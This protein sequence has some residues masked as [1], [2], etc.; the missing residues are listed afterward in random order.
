M[1]ITSNLPGKTRVAPQKIAEDP[2][3][4]NAWYQG[5]EMGMAFCRLTERLSAESGTKVEKELRCL[6]RALQRD[7]SKLCGQKDVNLIDLGTG[8]GQ[9][10]ILVI[11]ALNES[12]I[13]AVRYVPVD[14][15]PYIARYAILSI[16]GSGKKAWNKQEA[17]LLFGPFEEIGFMEAES[18]GSISLETL[19]RLSRS[20][21]MRSEGFV[22]KGVTVPMTGLDIDFF[23]HL[24]KVTS[25]AKALPGK[26]IN[27][28]CMLGNT[29]GNN[30]PQE[31]K[32]FLDTLC[33][34]MEEGDL[35]LLGVSLRPE[36]EPC[37][38][39]IRILEREYSVGEAFMR[40]GAD[41]PQSK[42]S[43]KYDPD[44]HCMIYGFERPDKSV[45][46]MGYSY[47]F[48][49]REAANNLEAAGFEVVA[50]E[51]YPSP[52]GNKSLPRVEHAPKYLTI[53]AR[54]AGG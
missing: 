4:K 31:R 53:L 40:L 34:E 15:N 8:D 23:Q 6:E 51:S 42:Y 2:L 18:R 27:I 12:G 48:D 20:H 16:L 33:H 50:C 35:F 19:V 54:K 37:A 17:E 5:F 14:T 11:K 25:A 29:L 46:D 24:P 26:G 41:H 28:F 52:D 30:L 45:Q 32:I 13:R 7:F 10:V 39:A 43:A 3:A 1:L 47:L 38:E 36:D 22:R 44:S 9:K 49:A 21:P